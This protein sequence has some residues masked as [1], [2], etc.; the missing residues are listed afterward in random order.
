MTAIA[1]I[2]PDGAGKTTIARRL[3][4]SGALPFKYIYMGISVASSNVR[5]P[6]SRLAERIKRSSRKSRTAS[7]GDRRRRFAI[8]RGIA[9][10]ANRLL[11][12]WF[13]QLVAWYYQAKGHVVLY[14]R[15]FIFDFLP[16]MEEP[17]RDTFD[18]RVHRWFLARLYPRPDLVL[19]LDAPGSVL[20]DRKGESSPEEL[21]RRRQV[22]LKAGERFSNFVR[23]D[24]TMPLEEVYIRV[25]EQIV[26]FH[27]GR[28]KSD[29]RAANTAALLS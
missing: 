3:E 16:A 28:R 21:E 11:E 5:L 29:P 13:R 7:T 6:T 4:A 17:H 14:D 12:E 19:F 10:L 23:I 15:H 8:L 24:G 26:R 20:Y 25:F 18:K 27:N 2:G 9:R 1:I 22:M